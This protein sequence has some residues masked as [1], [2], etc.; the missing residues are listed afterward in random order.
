[1]WAYAMLP[2]YIFRAED[3]RAVVH[4]CDVVGDIYGLIEQF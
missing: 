1:M 3:A 2:K 4:A